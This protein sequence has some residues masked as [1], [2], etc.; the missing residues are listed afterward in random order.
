MAHAHKYP[1]HWTPA[2]TAAANFARDFSFDGNT[3]PKAMAK[4]LQK[5]VK[6]LNNELNAD[7]PRAKFGLD[8]AIKAEQLAGIAPILHA[9]A[10]M[11]RHIC[12]P[13][14]DYTLDADNAEVVLLFSQWQGRNGATCEAI[15][16]AYSDRRITRKEL[17]EI[18][19]KGYAEIAAFLQFL[20]Y[21]TVIAE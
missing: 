2:Q 14:P 6:H 13:L 8:D 1:A 9:H 4:A 7:Y 10:L 17:N 21:L 5:A 12:L 15:H 11:V 16:R 20:D 18:V 3:G 19:H